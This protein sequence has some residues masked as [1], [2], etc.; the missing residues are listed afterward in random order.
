MSTMEEVH[1][2]IRILEGAATIARVTRH[3]P[4]Q[5]GDLIRAH[6]A[7]KDAEIA[8]LEAESIR[9]GDRLVAAASKYVDAMKEKDAEIARLKE[10]LLQMQNAAMDATRKLDTANSKLAAVRAERGEAVKAVKAAYVHLDRF[11]A[12][13]G[14]QSE[15]ESQEAV[16][17]LL[18]PFMY[19][20]PVIDANEKDEGTLN[21]ALKVSFK[22][23]E[24]IH[25]KEPHE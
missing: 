3:D 15:M 23:L 10:C 4:K 20:V 11:G 19:P 21:E 1:E 2:S 18:R 22:R 16:F 6:L 8:A 7:A 24:K 14:Y 25:D 13:D 5:D 17:D 9:R 12:V